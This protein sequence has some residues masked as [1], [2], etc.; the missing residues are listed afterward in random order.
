MSLFLRT[1]NGREAAVSH[2]D[3]YFTFEIIAEPRLVLHETRHWK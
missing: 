3:L 1:S 2:H